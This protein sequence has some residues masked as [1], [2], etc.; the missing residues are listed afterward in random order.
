MCAIRGSRP[1]PSYIR[2]SHWRQIVP[3]GVAIQSSSTQVAR[4]D[5]RRG[6]RAGGRAAR[7]RRRR[8]GRPGGRE[9]V[10]DRDRHVSPAVHDAE[11][12]LAGGDQVDGVPGLALGQGQREVGV[13]RRG[14]SRTTGATRP[15][16]AVENAVDAA[17]A[18]RRR[19]RAGAA[20]TRPPRGRPAAGA[21][22]STRC[23]P[24]SVSITPR[25]T[26]SSSGTPACFSSRL[27]CWD[28]ALGREAERVGGA[29]P[30]SRG[31]RRR[32]GWSGRPDQS[33]SDATSIT[34]M[35]IRWCFMIVVPVD[36]SA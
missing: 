13:R 2:G 34:C 1:V 12:A 10:G 5:P 22:A 11:V 7:S 15:R 9:V 27:T 14:A 19:R 35:I 36:W 18:R 31:C 20:R 28:T 23:R 26:R 33:C 30:P 32:G 6:R 4:G 21:P 29:R 25:P 24:W 17:G 16:I 8:R 3:S